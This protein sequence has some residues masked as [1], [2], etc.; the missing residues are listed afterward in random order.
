LFDCCCAG[1]PITTL[2]DTVS[3]SV[4]ASATPRFFQDIHPP[5]FSSIPQILYTYMTKIL[6]LNC[7]KL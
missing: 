5:L 6:V 4:R 7:E 2:V 3:T 1:A